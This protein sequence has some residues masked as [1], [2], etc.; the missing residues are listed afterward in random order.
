MEFLH[1]SRRFF[2]CLLIANFHFRRR[3]INCFLCSESQ[4]NAVSAY[5][6]MF[7]LCHRH[8]V[9]EIY[10]C[11]SMW[12]CCFNAEPHSTVRIHPNWVALSGWTVG[13]FPVLESYESSY[14]ECSSTCPFVIMYFHLS[15]V[16]TY[17]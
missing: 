2:S 7:G 4:V 17:G 12:Q 16:N 5:S 10:P 11:C 8:N 9:F 14:R 6:F 1:Y 13:F 3:T 15:L